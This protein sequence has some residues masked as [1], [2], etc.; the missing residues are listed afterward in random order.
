MS[1]EKG[2]RNQIFSTIQNK[3]LKRSQKK[4][5]KKEKKKTLFA[6][7]QENSKNQINILLFNLR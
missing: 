3:I 6:Q 7:M 5:P 2:W 1:L 4:K